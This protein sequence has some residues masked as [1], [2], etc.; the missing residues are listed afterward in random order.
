MIYYTTGCSYQEARERGWR[1]KRRFALFPV[2]MGL[3]YLQHHDGPWVWLETYWE[4]QIWRM[5]ETRDDRYWGSLN[6][7]DYYLE[8]RFEDQ[9]I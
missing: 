4:R 9:L 1:W 2:R 5:G 8:P 7:P 6:G 3:G